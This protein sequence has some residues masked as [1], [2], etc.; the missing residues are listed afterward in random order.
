MCL[1]QQFSDSLAFYT[2]LKVNLANTLQPIKWY[3]IGVY[4]GKH[5]GEFREAQASQIL[6]PC[7][8]VYSRYI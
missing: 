8:Q 2:N 4:G 1:L 7:C 3:L 6:E 5:V